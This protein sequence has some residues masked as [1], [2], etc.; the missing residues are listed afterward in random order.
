[1]LKKILKGT[2]LTLLAVLIVGGLAFLLR[3]DPIEM[4]PGK[5]L[6]GKVVAT[7][8]TWEICN[9]HYTMALEARPE[10]PHSVTVGCFEYEGGLYIP[11]SNP[12]EKLWPQ[13][14]EKD[15]NVRVK[16][17][18]NVYL[19]KAERTDQL[20]KEVLYELMSAKYPDYAHLVKPGESSGITMW[21][22]RIAGR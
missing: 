12:A 7:P 10:D 3:S 11:A 22:F 20:S 17:G 8:S 19:A 9:Q 18:E 13:L 6:S 14:V 15:P 5:R 2:G 16:I 21:I 4:I 1:M